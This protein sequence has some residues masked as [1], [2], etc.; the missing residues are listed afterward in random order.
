MIGMSDILTHPEIEEAKQYINEINAKISGR[1]CSS[2]HVHT[3]YILKQLL[4]DAF[5]NYLEIGT[6]HGG[7]MAL[8]L[9]SEYGEKHLGIDIFT[10]YGETCDPYDNN[11]TIVSRDNAMNNIQLM[12]KYNHDV[13][14][15]EGS[16]CDENTVS[17]VKSKIN[18]ASLLLIDGDHS[19]NGI[20]TDY[21]LYSP[22]IS[23][24][25]IIVFDDYGSQDWP[26]V[27][28]AV[29]SIDKRSWHIIGKYG[30]G[31]LMQKK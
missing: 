3:L 23:H 5:T 18:E 28:C 1:I 19:F 10:Y 14:L 20:L 26:Q 11:K 16:S 15:I 30:D 4:K 27:K 8:A 7:S 21:S 29:D 13:E 25:G 2:E 31:F 9:Q 12:N 6:L 17:I 24:G 22:F